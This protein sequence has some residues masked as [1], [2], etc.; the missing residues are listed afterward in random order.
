METI[1]IKFCKYCNCTHPL[2]RDHWEISKGRLSTCKQKRR[3]Y[4]MAKGRSRLNE[5]A[6]A[7]YHK[8]IQNNR[9]K[10]NAYK[11]KRREK[12]NRDLREKYA[13]SQDQRAKKAQYYATNKQIRQEY[14]KRYYEAHKDEQR[15]RS[16]K[17]QIIAR[18]NPYY[19]LTMCLRERLN[20]AIINNQK[21]GSAVKDLGC[22][23]PE[24][25]QYLESKF[26][27]GMSWDNHGLHGW[28][29]DHITPLASFD[30]TDREQ[31]LKA[32]HYT[33]LQPLWAK[34][35]LKKGRQMP[36]RTTT[37]SNIPSGTEC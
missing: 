23:I 5:I 11:D 21:S 30:L 3:D 26:Q 34:D 8:D 6:R 28:H 35:N 17:W 10:K 4:L 16:K 33:N 12:D 7:H 9:L 24:L 13:S 36:H 14:S 27:E 19:K 1:N 25:K 31:F 22:T 2:D 37:K 18:T 32:C 29:I 15:T 20:K